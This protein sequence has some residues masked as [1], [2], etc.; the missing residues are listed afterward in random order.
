MGFYIPIIY[1]TC[2]N[3]YYLTVRS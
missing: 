3:W 2:T 1:L